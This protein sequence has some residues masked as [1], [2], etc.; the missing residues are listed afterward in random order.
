MALESG[1]PKVLVEQTGR[2]ALVTIARPE[3][4]NAVDADVAAGL[5]RTFAAIDEAT[6]IAV[7][8]LT[9]AGATFC[10]GADLKG[11]VRGEQPVTER[12]GFGGITMR[13]PKTPVIAAVEGYAV[14]GGLELALSCDLIVAANDA[15][16]GLPEVKRGL[17][18]AGGGLLRL[19][20]RIPYHV[21]MEMT[22]TGDPITAERAYDLGLATT[23]T[24]PGS[25]AG[26]AVALAGRI[27]EGGP[28]AL[29]A[30]K[31]VLVRQ[32]DWGVEEAWSEQAAYLAPVFA[33]EDAKE[34]PLAF[35]EKRAP[36]WTGR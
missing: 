35:A 34:G 31:Q 2:I 29:R 13:P 11:I 14:A 28:L 19:P 30:S 32:W 24:V 4:R 16:F 10:A 17:A 21:A 27:A 15:K 6:D 7:A 22:L 33:S 5:E 9:G 18:A 36:N 20:R 8:V 12:G 3:A 25:A 23:L 1:T 26:A